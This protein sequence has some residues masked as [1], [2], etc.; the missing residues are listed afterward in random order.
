MKGIAL[1]RPRHMLARGMAMNRPLMVAV[2]AMLLTLAATGALLI[3]TMGATL[4]V[5]LCTR[6]LPAIP[7][8]SAA[9]SGAQ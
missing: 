8:A 7:L 5:L 4:I 6:R 1:D 3:A 2:V 9:S